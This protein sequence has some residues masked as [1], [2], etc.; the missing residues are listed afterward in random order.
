MSDFFSFCA[1]FST[2]IKSLPIGDCC[3]LKKNA[4]FFGLLYRD[5]K[6]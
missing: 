3:T 1:L 6:I 5:L 4:A 2:D